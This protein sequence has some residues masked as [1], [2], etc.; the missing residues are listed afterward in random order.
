MPR[1]GVGS[2][3]CWVTWLV[4]LGSDRPGNAIGCALHRKHSIDT[5]DNSATVGKHNPCMYFQ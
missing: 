3:R 5:V 1:E 2:I 4:V